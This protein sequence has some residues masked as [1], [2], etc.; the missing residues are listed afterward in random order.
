[1]PPTSNSAAEQSWPSLMMFE[2]ALRTSASCI[3]CAIASRRLRRTS[4]VTGSIALLRIELSDMARSGMTNVHE[5]TS[6]GADVRTLAGMDNERCVGLFD[7]RRAL[8][9][10]T[11]TQHFTVI[12]RRLDEVVTKI[13]IAMGDRRGRACIPGRQRK[14]L[15]RVGPVYVN[16]AQIDKF[17]R[18]MGVFVAVLGIVACMEGGG[19][20]S[21]RIG[22]V[23]SHIDGQ[24]VRL[25]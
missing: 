17:D 18:R 20:L 23:G 9:R 15:A 19:R 24:L 4:S 5:D 14:V 10:L 1:S 11:D 6:I 25:A 7:D 16:G 22:C 3:S 2:Y 12:N 13:D 8:D 21:D